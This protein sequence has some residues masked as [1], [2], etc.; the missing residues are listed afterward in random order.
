MSKLNQILAAE[1]QRQDRCINLI[2]S[3][4]YCPREILDLMSSCFTNKYAEGVPGKRYYE[5]CQNVDELENY[6]IEKACQLFNAEHANVQP[7]SGSD[8]NYLAY[9]ALQQFFK[10]ERG[11]KSVKVFAPSLTGGGHLTHGFKMNLSSQIL[12]FEHYS[13]Y[14]NQEV[15]EAQCDQTKPN[16]I[17]A[18]YSCYNKKLDLGFYKKLADKHNALLM[19]DMAHFAG[20]VAA[21][22]HDNPVEY[23]DIVT[24]TTHKTLKSVR[25]GVVLSKQYLKK[26]LDKVCPLAQGGANY[27]IIAGKA[28]G[29]ELA[30][31][32]DFKEY[33]KLVLQSTKMLAEYFGEYSENHQFVLNTMDKYS[34]TGKE[35]AEKLAKEFIFVNAQLTPNDPLPATK[36]SGI[37]VGTAAWISK[38]I[39]SGEFFDVANYAQNLSKKI[40]EILKS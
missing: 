1:Q 8:A 36:C 24:F 34:L 16:L 17:V 37:R 2:A 6:T 4:N 26:Y 3:E 13:N 38:I 29:F 35:A 19:V 39:D 20:L 27:S 32:P 40:D 30:Q 7:H 31:R 10:K 11:L 21:G 14:D 5:G 28:K 25:G 15:I 12:D 9:M 23:A 33:I 22:E 18:G